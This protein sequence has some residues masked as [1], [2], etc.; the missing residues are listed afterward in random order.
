MKAAED[1]QTF[2]LYYKATLNEN[3]VLIDSFDNSYCNGA[4]CSYTLGDLPF[5]T[6][7]FALNARDDNFNYSSLTDSVCFDVDDCMDYRLPNVFTPNDDGVNDL[8][9]PYQPYTNVEKI[10]MTIYNRW[11]RKVFHTEE[12]N[13]NWDGKDYLSKERCSDGTYFYS[14]DVSL[15]SLLGIVVV[16]LHGSITLIT[17]R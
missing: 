13:I 11:G 14:C 7:C 8:F 1:V 6:G 3:F 16:P 15:H 10:D 12:P 9:Q 4:Q 17:S 2:Y 5:V